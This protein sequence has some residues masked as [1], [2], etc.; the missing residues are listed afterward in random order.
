MTNVL[1]QSRHVPPAQTLTAA[2]L[3]LSAPFC[4]LLQDCTSDYPSI[5]EV[6]KTVYA[7]AP[8]PPPKPVVPTVTPCESAAA[9]IS[10]IGVVPWQ[11]LR[12]MVLVCIPAMMGSSLVHVAVSVQMP[13]HLTD[14]STPL[15]EACLDTDAVHAS[16][17]RPACQQ[18]HHLLRHCPASLLLLPQLLVAQLHQR[19]GS[20]QG[21]GW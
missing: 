9:H 10:D 5:C 21:A 15:S 6:P 4:P 20:L 11:R 1:R 18:R 19:Q 7:C 16:A 14:V 12:T 2:L 13:L 17:C 3:P 8:S